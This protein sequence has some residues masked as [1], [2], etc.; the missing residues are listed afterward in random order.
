MAFR[1]S[2][3]LQHK[4]PQKLAAAPRDCPCRRPR[5]PP[6]GLGL[7]LSFGLGSRWP[8]PTCRIS[9]GHQRPAGRVFPGRCSCWP[10]PLVSGIVFGLGFGVGSRLR[11]RSKDRRSC[12]WLAFVIYSS[13]HGGCVVRDM[14]QGGRASLQTTLSYP[15]L[16]CLRHL[17]AMWYSNTYENSSTPCA[18]TLL[19]Y[20]GLV[21]VP[22]LVFVCG[23]CGI[24]GTSGP[25]A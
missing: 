7:G 18:A 1:L 16:A 21:N 12:S 9:I 3:S 24:C 25:E 11:R 2:G 15:C 13:T 14:Q 4:T 19:P 8:G 23:I 10:N 6:K 20:R 22:A 17:H 5:P